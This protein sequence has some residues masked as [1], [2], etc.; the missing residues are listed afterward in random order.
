MDPRS[1]LRPGLLD[2]RTIALGGGGPFADGLG[3]LGATPATLPQTL[4]E[5]AAA[6]HVQGALAAH[7]ALDALV[8]DLR[9]AFGSGGHD[10]LRAALDGAW[11]TI[12]AVADAAWIEP[13]KPGRIVLVAPRPGSA[14]AEGVRGAVE[15]MARTLSIEWSRFG[16]RTVA[17]TPGAR[18]TDGELAAL[19]AYLAS[20]AG[21]YFSGAR[22]ALG[23][24][25]DVGAFAETPSPA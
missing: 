21:D 11:V 12:R 22:L 6:T 23:E 4:D 1:L 7:G 9:P 10:G 16:I 25:G 20:P 14:D 19:A 3:G 15:N 18:T 5:E 17:I 8:H 13:A 2:G 24:A